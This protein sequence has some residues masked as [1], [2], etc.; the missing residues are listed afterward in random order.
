MDLS[1]LKFKFIV[2]NGRM[3]IYDPILK[4]WSIQPFKVE[5]NERG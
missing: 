4:R 2:K 3:A 5:E 1:N